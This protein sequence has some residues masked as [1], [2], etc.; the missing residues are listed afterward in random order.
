MIVNTK[1]SQTLQPVPGLR[2]HYVA[3]ALV[4]IPDQ[5][6]TFRQLGSPVES[7]VPE[8]DYFFWATEDGSDVPLGPRLK[9]EVRR[10]EDSKPVSID[11]TVRKVKQ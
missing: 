7:Q 6:R 9:V 10:A 5:E 4:T 11:L 3:E 2:I 8:A 1:D